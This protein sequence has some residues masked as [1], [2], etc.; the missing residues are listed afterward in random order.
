[1]KA[2]HRESASAIEEAAARW[3]ARRDAGFLDPT[4]A[5]EFE[6]WM[7]ADPRHKAALA[8]HERAWSLADRAVAAGNAQSM[9]QELGARAS[10]RRRRR[11]A[12]TLACVTCFLL[13]GW[14]WNL[15]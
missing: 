10:R 4:Q 2:H 13:A 14:T 7:V 15:W 8:R 6:H 3:I 1:M 12:G 9:A 5:A 11:V